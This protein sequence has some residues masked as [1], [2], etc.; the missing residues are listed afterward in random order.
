MPYPRAKTLHDEMLLAGTE[1]SNEQLDELL[2]EFDT[3]KSGTIGLNELHAFLRFYDP[4]SKTIR[5]K[6]VFRHDLAR[7][8]QEDQEGYGRLQRELI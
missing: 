8:T 3:D 2:R 4:S 7:M 6:T 5:R 1:L